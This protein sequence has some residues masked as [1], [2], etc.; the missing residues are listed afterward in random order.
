[1]T[2]TRSTILCIAIAAAASI[3][4]CAT[5]LAPQGTATV[6]RADYQAAFDRTRDALVD[7]GFT[8]NRVDAAAGVVTTDPLI[9][10]GAFGPWQ[11]QQHT[12]GAEVADALHAQSRSV[13]VEFLPAAA[14]S[15]VP[16]DAPRS[17][18]DQ[19]PEP[20][21]VAELGSPSSPLIA[22]VTVLVERRYRPGTRPQVADVLRTTRAY[23]PMLNADRQFD[24]VIRRD[25]ELERAIA[26]RIASSR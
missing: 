6:E 26:G 19:G 10:R 24:V 16:T 20:T 11:R 3:G 8:L 22:R 7:L 17:Q 18:I 4:G 13:R 21:V 12:L 9:G 5:P 2:R 14:A 25:E 15:A 23:D 1:M